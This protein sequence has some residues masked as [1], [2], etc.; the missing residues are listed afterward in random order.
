MEMQYTDK[1]HAQEA[2]RAEIQQ[3]LK[4]ALET[5]QHLRTLVRRDVICLRHAQR[6]NGAV[7]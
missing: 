5:Q 6:I 3:Q 1:Q 7:N 4:V 2:E